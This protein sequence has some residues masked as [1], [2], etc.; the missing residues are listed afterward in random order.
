M[1]KATVS[2]VTA[3]DASDIIIQADTDR[4]TDSLGNKKTSFLYG[5]TAYF[6][7]Y[8]QDPENVSVCATD[9]IITSHGVFTEDVLDE[10]MTFIDQST[11]TPDKPV[12]AI[13][14]YEWAGKSLGTLTAQTILSLSCSTA[15]DAST[16]LIGTA[17]VSYR[18]AY[19][20]YG[21]TVGTKSRTEYPVT[22]YA[23]VKNG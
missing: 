11:A 21:I 3:S 20:L 8:A 6:R 14:S 10:P 15:P 9:G 1:T 23:G 7:V 5:D 17:L 4:N 13:N 16:G 2:F 22:V 19:K 18:T 12:Y